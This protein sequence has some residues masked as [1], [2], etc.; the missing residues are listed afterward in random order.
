MEDL[1]LPI[2]KKEAHKE[3]YLSM[4]DYLRFVVDNLKYSTDLNIGRALKKKTFVDV[5]FCLS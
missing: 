2:I 4:D 1:N 5:P 3:R